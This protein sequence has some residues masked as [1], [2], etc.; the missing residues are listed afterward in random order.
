MNT[1]DPD[2][3]R[4]TG[5]R[6]DNL[7]DAQAHAAR[8]REQT[9]SC[10]VCCAEVG[11]VEL[12]WHEGAWFCKDVDGCTWRACMGHTPLRERLERMADE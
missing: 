6:F 7:E 3:F 10:D 11:D 2:E 12:E 5:P 9:P 4:V 1:L 8:I